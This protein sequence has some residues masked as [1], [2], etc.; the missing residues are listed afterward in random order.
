MHARW[1][2]PVPVVDPLRA[3]LVARAMACQWARA[4]PG[5]L[6]RDLV[7]LRK[8]VMLPQCLNRYC[9]MYEYAL[10]V[11]AQH[12]VRRGIIP[13]TVTSV[14]RHVQ[15]AGASGL[16]TCQCSDSL[17]RDSVPELAAGLVYHHLVTS[18]AMWCSIPA[19]VAQLAASSTA[20]VLHHDVA[21]GTRC[22]CRRALGP[23]PRPA[24]LTFRAATAGCYQNTAAANSIFST[25]SPATAWGTLLV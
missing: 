9:S 4:T 7:R 18:S 8:A 11:C 16:H 1:S 12:T 23:A 22:R 20:V 15:N 13:V 14:P 19:P 5:S 10:P 6:D 3:P 17:P 24:R 21:V 2:R 25:T